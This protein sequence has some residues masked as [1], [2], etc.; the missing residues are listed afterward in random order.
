ML[1]NSVLIHTF[2]SL[3]RTNCGLETKTFLTS[4]VLRKF[5]NKTNILAQIISHAYDSG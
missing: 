1:L 2:S 3:D 5:L 4:R